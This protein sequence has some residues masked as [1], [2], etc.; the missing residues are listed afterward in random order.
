MTD[1]VN[2]LLV[3]LDKDIRTD[4]IGSLVNAIK[5]IKHVVDVKLNI[6]DVNSHI[7]KATA[8]QEFQTRFIELY[9]KIFE[10]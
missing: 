1:R 2:A 3:V 5:C 9:S 4:D 10:D 7:A 8:K 6:A